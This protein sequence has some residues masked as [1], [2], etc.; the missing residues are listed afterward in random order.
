MDGRCLLDSL[1]LVCII[2]CYLLLPQI[3][4]RRKGN[5]NRVSFFVEH[6][7]S[8]AATVYI[9]TYD[10][11]SYSF[12]ICVIVVIYVKIKILEPIFFIF[13]TKRLY[14]EH[15]STTAINDNLFFFFTSNQSNIL[16]AP[17]N[18]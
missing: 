1:V 15:V 3:L 11:T 14:W 16:T 18:A 17:S 2:Y 5:I 4:I 8:P 6:A 7:S 10:S 9:H 13:I 12:N